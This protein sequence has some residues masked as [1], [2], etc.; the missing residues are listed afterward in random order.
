MRQHWTQPDDAG[1]PLRGAEVHRYGRRRR[2]LEQQHRN[3]PIG[4]EP[5]IVALDAWTGD[6][7]QRRLRVIDG[8]L[9]VDMFATPSE[10]KRLYVFLSA[11]GGALKSGDSPEFPRVNWHAWFD[12][13]CVNIDDPTFSAFPGALQTGWYLGTPEQDAVVTVA[14]VIERIRSRFDIDRGEVVVIGSSAG[15]TAALRIAAAVPGA[16][17]IAENPPIYPHEQSSIQYFR[18]A[19]LEIDDG[20]L[21]QRASL[22]HILDHEQSRFLILQ[23]GEDTEVVSQLRR[24]LSEAQLP[25]PGI[26]LSETGALSLYITSV[27]AVSPHHAFL[28]AG[29]LVSVAAVA[30]RD[31]TPAMRGAVLDAVHESLRGRTLESDRAS[32]LEGWTR[33]LSHLDVPALAPAPPAHDRSVM[34]LPLAARPETTYRLRLGHRATQVFMAVDFT[35]DVCAAHEDDIAEIAA[36]LGARTKHHAEGTTLSLT[37]VPL[38]AAPQRLRALVDATAPLFT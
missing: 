7:A 21:L 1:S 32:N 25:L 22:R 8:A 19:G 9:A 26:G 17:A 27:P 11:G 6:L 16:T 37:R 2:T 10:T 15:G 18:R 28:S 34:R 4:A 35:P 12:G 14:A 38:D 33:L 5:S 3:E 31:T 13:V 24:L 29:E 30:R 23:N 36:T 20:P